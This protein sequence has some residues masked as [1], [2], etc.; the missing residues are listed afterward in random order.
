MNTF[1]IFSL[2][3]LCSVASA[4]AQNETDAL[5]Y[6]QSFISGTARVQ[7]A[8]GA[9][10]AVGA[11]FSSTVINPAGLALYRRNELVFSTALTNA[12]SST[13]YFGNTS[14]GN[15]GNL[16]LPSWG[17]VFTKVYSEMGQDV[18]TGLVSL[19]FGAGMNRIYSYQENIRFSG[20]NTQNSLLDYFKYSAGGL[21][22]ADIRDNFSNYANIAGASAYD[23]YLL[24][25]AANDSYHY[26]ALTDGVSG[27][28]LL[29][30]QQMKLRGAANE[31]NISGGAN[32][33]NIVYLGAGLV[34]KHAYSESTIL[35]SEDAQGTV[36]NYYSSSLKQ[37]INSSGTGWGGRFGLIVRPLDFLKLGIAA[38]TPIRMRMRDDYKYTV[39]GDNAFYTG[40][41]DP[42]RFDY[43]KY[44]VISPAHYTYSAAITVAKLGLLSVDY[45]TVDYTKMRMESESDF[46]TDANTNIK[47]NMQRA[48]NLRIGAEVKIADYYRLRGGYAVYGNPYKNN[49]GENLDRQ[50]ITGGVGF[51]VDRVFIDFAVVNSFGKQFIAPY[52]TGDV[53]K[54]DP[55]A[56]NTYNT[57]NFVLSGGIRF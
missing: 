45:E 30:Q 26:S 52:T 8:G 55:Q 39:S 12:H 53:S 19:S 42:G 46:F 27:Y 49:G 54:P 51:L 28:K 56:I 16:N 11:D 3:I 21:N 14:D 5:N 7:G 25:T 18:K 40:T 10:G 2:S 24:D 44:D 33:S 41:N 22:A 20:Q 43:F 57:L 4:Y 37:E 47:N 1:K 38:Q 36:P 15:R 31:Y 13:S 48:N 50:A 9:F 23:L 17:G 29:Q 34:L 32:L 6:S 35:M